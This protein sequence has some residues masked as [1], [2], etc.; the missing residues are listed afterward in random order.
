MASTTDELAVLAPT[1]GAMRPAWSGFRS[2]PDQAPA[3]LADR[4]NAE[5]QAM[6]ANIAK[7]PRGT[8]RARPI[9]LIRA[10]YAIGVASSSGV[11]RTG[12]RLGLSRAQ[13]LQHMR[14][15]S[16]RRIRAS[17]RDGLANGGKQ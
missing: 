3:A 13:C 15:H 17:L 6:A 2:G 8:L 5:H 4:P 9:G 10:V 7:R 11:F 1:D 12:D 16:A 14:E